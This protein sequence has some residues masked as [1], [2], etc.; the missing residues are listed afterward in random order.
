MLS[1]WFELEPMLICSI[2]LAP[3]A[4]GGSAATGH[5]RSRIQALNL[6]LFPPA[7]LAGHRREE[8]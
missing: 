7:A 8:A 4:G 6:L 2:D 1:S 3:L 5:G